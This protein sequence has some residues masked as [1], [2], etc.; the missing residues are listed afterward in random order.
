MIRAAAI[1]VYESFI[2]FF[3]EYAAEAYYSAVNRFRTGE[4]P[5][6]I[7]SFSLANQIAVQA[8]EIRNLVDHAA[9]AR[10][11]RR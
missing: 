7:G 4:M 6:M 2:S 9:A 8:P 3:Q 10:H 11:R 1:R 5:L